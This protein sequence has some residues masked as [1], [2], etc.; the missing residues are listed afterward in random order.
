MSRPVDSVDLNAL[1]RREERIPLP[2]SLYFV[3]KTYQKVSDFNRP[4]APLGFVGLLFDGSIAQEIASRRYGNTS[5]VIL[6]GLRR[7]EQEAQH[8]DALRAAIDEGMN[9]GEPVDGEEAFAQ[10]RKK[11]GLDL[12]H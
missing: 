5:E 10:M 3:L 7:L 1:D 4:I 8:R 12:A 9:S 6:A 2:A 11:H